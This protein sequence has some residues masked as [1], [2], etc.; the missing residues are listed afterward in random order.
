MCVTLKILPLNSFLWQLGLGQSEP[1]CESFNVLI[2]KKQFQVE[3]EKKNSSKE[4]KIMAR[5]MFLEMQM[6]TWHFMFPYVS[7]SQDEFQQVV[8]DSWRTKRKVK[9]VLSQIKQERNIPVLKV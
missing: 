2:H 3:K 5:K 4:K 9:N 8:L 6:E 7:C 1:E